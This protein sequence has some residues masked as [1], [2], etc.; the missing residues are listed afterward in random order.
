MIARRIVLQSLAAGA[1]AIT[2]G[3]RCQ[4]QDSASAV[5]A[6]QDWLTKAPSKRGAIAEQSFSATALSKTDAL[7]AA[8]L[9]W[10]DFLARAK[11]EREAEWKSRVLKAADKKM[12]FDVRVFGE[13]PTG[14][15]SLFIS[16]HG[17]GN[18]PAEINERQWENQQRLYKPDEGVY[19]A[20]RA[21]T[22][23]WNLWHEAHIDPLFERLITGAVL[24][25]EVNPDRVYLMGYSAGGDGVYQLA[26]RLADRFAAA[27]M[28]A[29]HPN[30]ASPLGLRNLPFCIHCGAND[31]AYNRNQVCEAWG[32]QLDELQKADPQ[33]YEH[34]WKL[35]AGKPHWMD[36]QDAEALPWM[37]KFTRNPAPK[38]IVWRQDDVTR[39]SFYWLAM[40]EAACKAGVEVKATIKGNEIELE[41]ADPASIAIRLDDRLVDLDMPVT[42]RA[43]GKV[44]FEGKAPRTIGAL[45]KT[46]AERED[47]RLMFLAEVKPS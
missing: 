26:P 10:A 7:A 28:M 18:A 20:P 14:G 47:R 3:R 34:Y 37:V 21:P 22:N 46:L 2:F 42:L 36:R 40:A 44:L 31:K 32:K 19:I 24:F 29:G 13:K 12:K 5:T 43:G 39:A 30:E 16:M 27:S 35:H 6:L 17:G 25:E 9:L 1:S 15:R 4:A 38:K 45:A 41:S 8:D 23:T 11:S 33:G